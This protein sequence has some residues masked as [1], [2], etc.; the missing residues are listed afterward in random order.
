MNI[1]EI[2]PFH[3]ERIDVLLLKEGLPALGM[4]QQVNLINL[5][6]QCYDRSVHIHQTWNMNKIHH[7]TL[8]LSVS[9]TVI[10]SFLI[11]LDVL[12]ESSQSGKKLLWVPA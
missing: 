7:M 9:A 3:T 1:F 5:Q 8:I 10:V 12:L 2:A 6:P 4:S 11:D